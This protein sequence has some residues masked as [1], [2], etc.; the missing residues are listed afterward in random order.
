[1]HHLAIIFQLPHDEL[2]VVAGLDETGHYFV[3]LTVQQDFTKKLD[4]LAL[5]DITF[6]LDK[7]VVVLVEEEVEVCI[8][9]L[10]DHRLVPYENL[11]SR[12]SYWQ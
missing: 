1:L 5:G 6:R 11:L 8:D 4:G 3:E 10:G 7:D 12:L 2:K 9:K